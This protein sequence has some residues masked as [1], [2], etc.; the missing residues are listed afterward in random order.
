MAHGSIP[1]VAWYL[2][3]MRA[4]EEQH[5]VRILDYLDL[6]AYPNAAGIY[7]SV[8]G[9]RTTQA[10]RLRSTRQ[11]WDP[12][13]QDE[14]WV[15]AKIQLI[16]RMRAWVDEN[17]PGTRLALT[18][19]NWGAWGYMNGALAQAD[20]LGIFGREGLDLATLWDYPRPRTTDPLVMTFRM[21]R[22]YDGTGS[23]FGD[24]SVHAESADQE[25]LAI[26]A[27]EQGSKLTLMF[28]NKSTQEL[29]SPVSLT[30]F[31][32]ASTAQVY[33]YSSAN[34]SGIVREDDQPMTSTGF[35]GVFPASSI[36]LVVV[37]QASAPV[38]GPLTVA[39]SGAG[40]GRITSNPAGIDCGALCSFNFPGSGTVTLTATPSPG[41][42][43]TG[44]SGACS[45]TGGCAVTPEAGQT[46][47]AHFDQ[48]PINLMVTGYTQLSRVRVNSYDYQ[49]IYRVNVNN[50]GGA[51][52]GVTGTLQ[53]PYPQ[54]MTPVDS[55]L[56]LG[57]LAHGASAGDTFS[58]RQDRR[59]PLKPQNLNWS[60]S[61]H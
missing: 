57:N 12:N 27:A 4:Y 32:P 36:T 19:Y 44:W 33:R 3:Q 60:F 34:I 47:T 39:R 9:D 18:E 52:T 50:Q 11:L 7:T 15:P 8:V 24:T 21:Y 26:Y 45:G 46:A 42:V 56:S 13:Y 1:L 55:A 14:S 38:P 28:V 41:S 30:G 43:F 40:E 6:H 22:N 10:L 35:N 31:N 59:Y 61:P 20:I 25:K 2:Q 54:G 53:P 17:Y 58:F 16:P 48:A 49:Y 51:G 29:A 5:G 23:R 37:E